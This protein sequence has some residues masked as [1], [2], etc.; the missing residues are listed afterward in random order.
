[1][2]IGRIKEQGELMEAYH[3]PE[4]KFVVVY[5]RRRVGKTYLV[6]Q[7]FK[8][9]FT[10]AHSGQAHAQL[11]EQ[12]FGWC[13]SLKDSG[14]EINKLPKNWLEAFELLK[15]H[16]RQSKA[17][18]KVIF[19][20]ELPWLDTPRS[21]FVNAL[22]FFWNGWASG[23]DDV[24]LVVCGSATSWIVNIIFKNHGGLHNRVTNQIYLQPFNLHECEE[25]VHSMNLT[26][27]RYDILEGYMVM[28]GVPYYWSMLKRGESMAQNI[29]RLFFAANGKLRYE[30]NEL[31][32]SLFRN[33]DKYITIVKVLGQNSSGMSRDEIISKA[34]IDNGGNL[35]RVLEDLEHCGFIQYIRTNSKQ[36]NGGIYKLVDNFTLFYLKFMNKNTTNDDMFWTHNYNGSTRL[37]WVGLAFERVC[38]QHIRQIKDALK[39][40]GMLSSAYPLRISD[41]SSQ[42]KGAQIDMVIDRADNTVNLCEIKFSNKEFLIDKD[43]SLALQNKIDRFQEHTRYKKTVMLTMITTHGIAHTG[44]WNMVQNEVTADDLFME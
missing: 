12:L 35:S 44:Y 7:T 1:M 19:I 31:Y 33:P 8:D 17:R 27:T 43:Y 9:K 29:D 38:F 13:A 37:S 10:F 6:R 39:I 25:Y 36:K 11:S 22:E 42:S 18:K 5:G 26:F 41:N 32:Q 24:L 30:F 15:D 14:M 3:A 2:L 16:I 28:G 23:R 40:S 21:R 4:S 20:D 34:R